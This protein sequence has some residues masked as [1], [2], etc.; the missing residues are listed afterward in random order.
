MLMLDEPSLGM[1]PPI[2]ELHHSGMTRL[3]AE[4]IEPF[5]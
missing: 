4:Q 5:V 3:I 2:V 1:V